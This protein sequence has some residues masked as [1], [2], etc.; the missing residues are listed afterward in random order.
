MCWW[1]LQGYLVFRSIECSMQQTTQCLPVQWLSRFQAARLHNA[2][3]GSQSTILNVIIESNVGY[4][5]R[6]GEVEIL[7]QAPTPRI[8]ADPLISMVAP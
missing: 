7:Q 4:E 5:S 6:G 2:D 8:L 1:F 3:L